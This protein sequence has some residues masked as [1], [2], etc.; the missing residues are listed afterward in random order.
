MLYGKYYIYGGTNPFKPTNLKMGVN[1]ITIDEIV[2]IGDKYYIK[3][4]NFTQYKAKVTLDGKEL[5]TIYLGENVLGLLEDVDPDDADKMKVSQIENKSGEIF[6]YD[7]IDRKERKN[8]H[9]KYRNRTAA[10]DPMDDVR[11][12]H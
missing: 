4:R 9:E 8:S 2:K 10:A 6:K 11:R 7:R 12:G 5:K 1:D 3:G